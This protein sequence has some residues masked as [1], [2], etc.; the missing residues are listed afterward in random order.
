MAKNA[1]I[2]IDVQNY[3]VNAH[4]KDLP[5]KIA[6]FID[7][8]KFDFVLFTKFINK[9]NSQFFKKLYWKKCTQSPDIDIH[10]ELS[11]FVNKDNVFEKSTYSIF[12]FV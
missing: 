2:V 10:Q 11:R 7:S 6:Q 9:K 1:L 8:N 3:Y 4:T 5:E 12:V